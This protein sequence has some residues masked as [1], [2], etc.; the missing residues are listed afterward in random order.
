MLVHFENR[1]PNN[2]Q[3][4]KPTRTKQTSFDQRIQTGD[5]DYYRKQ[6]A[7]LI[8]KRD[9]YEI[10]KK[11]NITDR[12]VEKYA[13]QMYRTNEPLT[14]DQLAKAREAAVGGTEV[15]NS[16]GDV[17]GTTT[18]KYGGRLPRT[19]KKS[20]K[21]KSTTKSFKGDKEQTIDDVKPEGQD[22]VTQS[23][24][25]ALGR[26]GT[27]TY[28]KPEAKLSR[29]AKAARAARKNPAAAL[30]IYDLGKGILGKIRAMPAVRGGR[31][32]QVSA[33]K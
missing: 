21:Y 23:K 22:R 31:A 17:V 29:V 10:D 15:K 16:K 9:E 6:R 12:G 32:I 19:Y 8:S 24:S 1:K 7:N 30:A 11:G 4:R 25:D 26:D 33:G 2:N 5:P 27:V 3:N 13:R 18:G 20:G 28:G 14:Q